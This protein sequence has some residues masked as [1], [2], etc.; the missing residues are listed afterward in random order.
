MPNTPNAIQ[1][2]ADVMHAWCG[3]VGDVHIAELTSLKQTPY[4][5]FIDVCLAIGLLWV[6]TNIC[7]NDGMI[8]CLGPSTT[9]LKL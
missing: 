3:A 6:N 8:C 2:N 7:E 5:W 4:A 1:L 9:Y